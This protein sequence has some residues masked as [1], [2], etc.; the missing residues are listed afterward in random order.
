MVNEKPVNRLYIDSKGD[1]YPCCW[2][3]TYRY[4]YKTIFSPKF[5]KYN[6]KNNNIQQILEDE[7]VKQFFQSTKSYETADKCCKMYCGVKN[8]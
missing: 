2:I 3:G 7:K 1:F 8:G 6:I 5:K 4:R